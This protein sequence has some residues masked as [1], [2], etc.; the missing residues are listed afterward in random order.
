M[1]SLLW[2]GN[3]VMFMGLVTSLLASTAQAENYYS[4]LL[5]PIEDAFLEA[6]NTSTEPQPFWLQSLGT[7]P[8]RETYVEVKAHGRLSIPLTDY[9]RSNES[10]VAVKTHTPNLSFQA[11]CKGSTLTWNLT[12]TVSPWKTLAVSPQESSA[13]LHLANL[14]QQANS[15]EIIFES[16]WGKL[17][18]QTVP[19]DPEFRDMTQVLQLPPGTKS[20]SM[21][22]PGRWNGQVLSSQGKILK[23]TEERA[24]LPG[25]LAGTRYFLFASS[26]PDTHE[27]FVVPMQNAKL[28]QESLDQIAQPDK[29]RLLVARIE[30]SFAGVNRN[31]ADGAP[32]SW[33]VQEAQNYADFAHISCDGNPQIVEERLNSWLTETGGTICFWSYRVLREVSAH[34]LAPLKLTQEPLWSLPALAFPQRK[35]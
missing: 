28:I 8:F 13:T 10:A 7:S 32:W 1:K 19:L 30:K 35:H 2:F 27:T 4:P 6:Q 33:Q 18:S 22:A 20:L 16:Y 5:C 9:Y 12:A 21:R 17:G 15:V 31:S 3:S 26:D 11:R 29:A 14:S 23:L 24:S 25:P 34:E